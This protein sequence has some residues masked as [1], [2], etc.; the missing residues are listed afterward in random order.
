MIKHIVFC[1]TFFTLFELRADEGLWLP[2]FINAL[3][4]QDMKKN[5]FKLTA[6][7]LYSINKISMKDGVA[8]FGGG[9]TAEVISKNGLILTNHHCGYGAINA[10]SSVEKNLL[11]NGFFAKSPQEELPCKGLSVTF[12]KLIEDVS[13]FV[14]NHAQ[15]YTAEQQRDSVIKANTV[16]FE[17]NQKKAGKTGFVRGF[18]YGNVFYWIETQTF[19]D[20]RLVGAPPESIGKFGGETDNWVWPRH[21]ADFSLFRIYANLKNEPS[22]YSSEN[23][24]YRPSYHFTLNASGIQEGDFTMVYGFPGRTQE[25]LPSAALD[26][27]IQQQD[28]LRTDIRKQRLEI[29]EQSMLKND[30][31]SLMYANKYAGIANAYKKWSGEWVGLKETSALQKKQAFE[32]NLI[33]QTASDEPLQHNIK[34]VLQSFNTLY[35]QYAPY[36]YEVDLFQECLLGVDVFKLALD[37]HKLALEY[38][39]QIAGKPNQYRELYA[40]V[41]PVLP[42][43]NIDI[44]T[45]RNLGTAMLGYYFKAHKSNA[46]SRYAD[47]M[48]HS[49]NDNPEFLNFYL[50]QRSI[51]TQT[52]ALSKVLNNFESQYLQ[53]YQDPIIQFM[54]NLQK[55]YQKQVFIPALELE[56]QLSQLQRLY[57]DLILK[58]KLKKNL[59]P[60]A[61]GTL[62][63]AYGKIEGYHPKDGI[64]MNYFTTLKGLMEKNQTGALDFE[65]PDRLK[66]LYQ[67]SDYGRYADKDGQLHTAFIASNHTTG[68][69]SGSPVLNAMGQLIGTNFDRNWEGTMSDLSYDVRRCRNIVLD[70]RFTLWIIDK[71]A[72]AGY[73]INE[74]DVV[75]NKTNL[76]SVK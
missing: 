56:Q 67:K 46:A 5:G 4:I 41:I 76:K 23:I 2:Q 58:S 6:E 49:F 30:T 38:Q 12:I 13:G 71:Y 57:M 34:T 37:L 32:L 14:L 28:P 26:L 33:K 3:N 48:Y 47:S 10:L 36:S 54:V 31:L 15:Q 16:Q 73:L 44:N 21:N 11:K 64:Y 35:P 45:D 17:A 25:Y 53:L 72:E 52:A 69:N 66:T 39:K 9:C 24:P 40:R 50:F 63:I 43:K 51:L 55:D 68:G 19:T 61:N 60:D 22:A 62:R 70:I 65:I 20:L 59:Y 27:I 29:I 7:Q 8:L 18:Y 1:C 75:W 74:M 42:Y